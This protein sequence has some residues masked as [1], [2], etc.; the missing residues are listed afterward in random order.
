MRILLLT[1]HYE[2][3]VGAPQRRW[4]QL[5][6]RL[7]AMGHEVVVVTSVPHY[8]HGRA[9]A[10]AP[11][12]GTT[13][14]R[15]GEV[16]VRVRYVPY[17]RGRGHRLVDQLVVAAGS[18]VPAV[19]SRPDVVV[20]TSPGLPTL[21][22]GR[23][24]ASR[25]GAPLVLELRD[26]WP[27]LVH[28]AAVGPSWCRGAVVRALTRLQRR[29]A[30]VVCVSGRF[31]QVLRERGVRAGQVSNGVDLGAT[32]LLPPVT[33]AAALRVVYVGTV[34]ESQD[35]AVA[36]RALQHLPPGSVELTVVG[37][38]AG[39]AELRAA[40]PRLPRPADVRLLPPV[41]PHDVPALL[42]GADTVLVCLRDWPALARTVPS[43]LYEVLA[44]GRHVSAVL[45]GEGADIVR[46]AG[47]GDVVTPGDAAG[48]AALWR[49][50]ST[51]RAATAVGTGPRAWVAEHADV[52]VL[53]ARY[54]DVLTRLVA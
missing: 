21:W 2:P 28:D 53:A 22:L 9:P 15:H 14:G 20:A 42:A 30:A 18:L 17:D 49:R 4:A 24:V 39:L 37:Q 6:P 43:K 33:P 51:D 45:A 27:D 29:A 48:L 3:E 46:A 23:A 41:A 32:Q 34:G 12:P 8:P 44:S 5:V 19:R 31:A 40:V 13:T 47:A 7:V 25:L 11:G 54:V 1:H 36:V 35:V 10:S 50:L 52:D 16:V 38:G 26:A